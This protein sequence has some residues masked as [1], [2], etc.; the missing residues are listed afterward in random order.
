VTAVIVSRSHTIGRAYK[1]AFSTPQP[2][3][4]WA[5][6]LRKR[7]VE[8][9]GID[10]ANGSTIVVWASALSSG[11]TGGN[12]ARQVAFGAQASPIEVLA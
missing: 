4:R 1:G 12:L 3:Q 5:I 8:R 7:P 10:P 11:S 9:A 2:A 6:I